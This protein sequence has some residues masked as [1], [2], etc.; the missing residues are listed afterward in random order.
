MLLKLMTPPV[1][2]DSRLL[3]N[4]LLILLILLKLMTPTVLSDRRLISTKLLI[5]LM[6]LKLMTPTVLSDRLLRPNLSQT[7]MLLSTAPRMLS[8]RRTRQSSICRWSLVLTSTPPRLH[9][10]WELHLARVSLSTRTGRQK[11]GTLITRTGCHRVRSLVSLGQS[12]RQEGQK[13]KTMI[14]TLLSLLLLV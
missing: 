13:R 3:L 8:P 6:L 5:L 11:V 7:L 4:K 2:S 1:L 9:R 14:Q 12:R 10:S